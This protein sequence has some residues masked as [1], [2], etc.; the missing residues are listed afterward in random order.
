M[1]HDAVLEA[2]QEIFRRR[3]I[4][5]FGIVTIRP[6]DGDQGNGLLQTGLFYCIKASVGELKKV[7]TDQIASISAACKHVDWP[8]FWRSPLK[9]NSD[10]TQKQDDY[11]GW[12]AALYYAHNPLANDFFEYAESVGWFINIQKPGDKTDWNYY[13][14]R[15]PGFRVFA[16]MCA[17]STNGKHRISLG[18]HIEIALDIF[19]SAFHIDD[20][21]GCMR[22]YCLISVARRESIL[23]AAVAPL[24]FYRVRKKYGTVGKAFSAYFQDGNHPLC[25][26]DWG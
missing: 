21:D 16:K 9:K 24:W 5:S 11:Y 4:N 18:E 25:M 17:R 10:D 3:Y 22:D 23:A 15:F 1:K 26:G 8:M 14:E 13:F 20:S 7:Y 6:D 12:L 2:E 19:W